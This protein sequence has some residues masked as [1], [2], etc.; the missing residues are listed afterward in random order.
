MDQYLEKYNQWLEDAYFDEMDKEE[1]RQLKD[2]KEI[3]ERF[4]TDLEFG[5]G[6]LRGI[7]GIG[8]NRI[9][10]YTVRKATYGF[11]KYLINKFGEI[12]QNR[13]IVIAYDSRRYS[14][15]FAKQAA[16]VLAGAGIKAYLFEYLVPTPEL[17]FAVNHLNAVGGIVITA[18]HNPKEYNGY[19][20]YDEQGCQVVPHVAKEIIAEIDQID[21]Y[22]QITIMDE[23]GASG[24]GLLE[25]VGEEVS[26]AFEQ[27]VLEQSLLGD[28][29]QSIKE[30]LNVVYTPIHGTGNKPVRNV[31]EKA[32]FTNVH[33][34]AVQELPDPEFGT[35]KSPNPEERETLSIAIHEAENIDAD[36]VLGTDPD[37]DRV[38]VAV[39]CGEEFEL[40]TGNQIG[41][42]LVDFVLKHKKE[43]GMI[44]EKSTLVKTIVT[45][46]LG[47]NIAKSYGL[48]T[49]DTLTGFKFIGDKIVEFNQTQMNEFIIGYE[50][51]YGYLV[52]THAKDKD[53][54]VSS[55]LICEMA[56]YYKKQG[57]NLVQVLEDLYEVYGYYKDHLDSFTLKGVEGLG[58]IKSIMDEMRVN[59][60]D[61]IAGLNIASIKDYDKGI[62]GLPKSDVLKYFLEDGSWVAAR[63]SGTEPK[64]KFYYSIVGDTA[65][66]A[67][68]KLQLIRIIINQIVNK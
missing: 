59:Y 61:Q 27:A 5:T 63:P 37:C 54:V 39:R 20:V 43:S 65:E 32:G 16:L 62:D 45:S 58:K 55:L 21:D 57:K 1:L 9:N 68:E 41:A 22:S 49:M 56:A 33:V 11:A 34:V 51:S 19:K 46:E 8:T 48:Q 52:G 36:I 38:G 60:T 31:L 28:N 35:V 6:G 23:D 44:D 29:Y 13:G 3:M 12:G 25:Y 40:L 2:D 17:S 66:Q 50:E 67:N 4:Y 53:A 10:K 18:S 24:S 42:L 15:L 7:I 30:C 47:A 14:D 26:T 64:I